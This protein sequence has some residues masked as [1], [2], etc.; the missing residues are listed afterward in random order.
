[1]VNSKL[2]MQ[3]IDKLRDSE[4]VSLLMSKEDP[5]WENLKSAAC[6]NVLFSQPSLEVLTKRC[7]L[8]ATEPWSE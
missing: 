6:R 3:R 5:L 2:E 1:M 4:C 8:R 7:I